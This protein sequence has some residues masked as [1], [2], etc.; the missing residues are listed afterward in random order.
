MLSQAQL[1]DSLNQRILSTWKQIHKLRARSLGGVGCFLSNAYT[2]SC[3][4][5]FETWTKHSKPLF[6]P[7][8]IIFSQPQTLAPRSWHHLQL[9]LHCEQM[10]GAFGEAREVP[11]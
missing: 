4:E 2:R 11:K 1:T 7:H 9:S 8:G 3:S 6:R 5:E 10:G